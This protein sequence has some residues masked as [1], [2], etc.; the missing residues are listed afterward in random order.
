[1]VSG[2]GEVETLEEETLNLIQNNLHSG[3]K[4]AQYF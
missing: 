2:E 4:R 3:G 1:M